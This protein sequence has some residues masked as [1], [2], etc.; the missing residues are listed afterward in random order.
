M[1]KRGK[2]EKEAKLL[3]AEN[4][5]VIIIMND[6]CFGLL[7]TTCGKIIVM[8]INVIGRMGLVTKLCEEWIIVVWMIE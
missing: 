5:E 8:Q 4:G 6:P 1:K 3:L 2:T 7:S